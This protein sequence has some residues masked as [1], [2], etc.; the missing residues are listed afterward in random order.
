MSRGLGKV[1]VLGVLVL[2]GLAAG[3]GWYAATRWGTT[4]T[5]EAREK[6]SR[7]GDRAVTTRGVVGSS[8]GVPLTDY[9][10]YKILDDDGYLWVMSSRGTPVE[11]SKV[12]VKGRLFATSDLAGTCGKEGISAEVC[13]AVSGV[14]RGVSGACVLLEDQRD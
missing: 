14:L 10:L 6:C 8:L 1:G 7:E 13:K 5:K 12:K 4:S 9:G 11:G 2:L 3:G